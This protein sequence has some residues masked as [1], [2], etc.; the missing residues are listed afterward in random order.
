MGTPRPAMAMVKPTPRTIGTAPARRHQRLPPQDRPFLQLL[1]HRKGVFVLTFAH[2]LVV[3][4][5]AG[6]SG[7]V[8][9]CHPTVGSVILMSFV[10]WRSKQTR[11]ERGL[12][13]KAALV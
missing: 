5:V 13:E 1:R 11:S 4:H 7:Q 10:W 2:T 12:G 8:H 6:Q 3:R 9:M